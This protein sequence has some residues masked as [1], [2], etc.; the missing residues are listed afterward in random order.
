MQ[1]SC[2]DPGLGDEDTENL[3]FVAGELVTVKR[4]IREL[5]A[6]IASAAEQAAD[7][8][9]WETRK[10]VVQRDGAAIYWNVVRGRTV[11][12]EA[13]CGDCRAPAASRQEMGTTGCWTSSLTATA[14]G[15]SSR[16]AHIRPREWRHPPLGCRDRRRARP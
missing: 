12:R 8:A 5:L 9:A 16:S 15:R 7:L 14:S 13:E 3:L 2:R 4:G 11:E 10:Q 6:K 1:W